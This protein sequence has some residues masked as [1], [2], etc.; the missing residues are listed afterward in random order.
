MRSPESQQASMRSPEKAS[1][2][3]ASCKENQKVL[4][5]GASLLL[6]ENSARQL[7]VPGQSRLLD[8]LDV[9]IIALRPYSFEAQLRFSGES[10]RE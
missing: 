7:P 6:L 5:E 10:F 1:Q 4:Y 8:R 9:L 2:Q 3:Q